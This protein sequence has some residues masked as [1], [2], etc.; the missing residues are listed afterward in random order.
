MARWLHTRTLVSKVT[1]SN[2]GMYVFIIV[3]KKPAL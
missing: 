3:K 1:G 2:P